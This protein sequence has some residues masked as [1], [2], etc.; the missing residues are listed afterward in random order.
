MSEPEL[1]ELSDAAELCGI[2]TDV[3]QD[4]GRRWGPQL[5]AKA[6]AAQPRARYLHLLMRLLVVYRVH[7]E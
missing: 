4:A 3:R 5:A 1:A 7:H 2:P 6:V